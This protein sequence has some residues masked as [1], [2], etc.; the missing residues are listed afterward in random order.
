MTGA[1]I[2]RLIELLKLRAGDEKRLSCTEVFTIARDLEMPLD[3]VGKTCTELGIK[4][5][6]CQLGCF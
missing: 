6:A 4:I 1:N 3:E 5:V 2:P